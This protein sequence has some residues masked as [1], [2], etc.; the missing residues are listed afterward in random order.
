MEYFSFTKAC[1]SLLTCPQCLLSKTC[2]AF[3]LVSSE[4]GIYFKC[5]HCHSFYPLKQVPYISNICSQ[6]NCSQQC[7]YACTHGALVTIKNKR[8]SIDYEKCQCCSQCVGTC[9]LKAIFCFWTPFFIS[10]EI[11]HSIKGENA[12]IEEE[13]VAFSRS[14]ARDFIYFRPQVLLNSFD[15][16]L[17]ICSL[18]DYYNFLEKDI[19]ESTWIFLSN[20]HSNGNL[21]ALIEE[22][23]HSIH[24]VSADTNIH[25][26]KYA[27]NYFSPHEFIYNGETL[28]LPSEKI[29]IVTVTHSIGPDCNTHESL[30][31]MRRILNWKGTLFVMIPPSVWFLGRIAGNLLSIQPVILLS[32]MFLRKIRVKARM[33]T[34]PLLIIRELG[35]LRIGR[36]CMLSMAFN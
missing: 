23:Y 24:V 19:S 12:I 3:V 1:L 30:R 5:N 21:R 16:A 35:E 17:G 18:V 28:P 15:A 22:N 8:M 20:K 6:K 26:K 27:N 4:S 10:S 36:N 13:G 25:F 2:S 11:R 7:I 32:I 31:E 14:H 9:P 29:D 33:K 34:Y